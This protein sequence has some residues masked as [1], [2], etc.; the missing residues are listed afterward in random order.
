MSMH[1]TRSCLFLAAAC[2]MVLSDAPASQDQVVDIVLAPRMR[3]EA[4]RRVVDPIFATPGVTRRASLW[5]IN[6]EALTASAEVLR[7]LAADPTVESMYLS[8]VRAPERWSMGHSGAGVV[9]AGADSGVDATHP[10]LATRFRGGSNNW[11]DPNGEHGPA[12]RRP[13]S[14]RGPRVRLVV[15][16]GTR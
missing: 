8:A 9:V 14:A 10:D 6:G 15:Q 2:W 11:Y 3:A 5:A 4:N 16:R 12:D 13:P 1:R 7:A